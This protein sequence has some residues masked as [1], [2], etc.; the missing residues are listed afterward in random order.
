MRFWLK[1]LVLLSAV[2]VLGC[3]T[4]AQ[5]VTPPEVTAKESVIKGLEGLIETGQGGSEIGLMMQEVDKLHSLD[6]ELAKEL[7]N[8]LQNMMS[9][10]SPEGIKSKAA[11]LLEKVKALDTGG[12]AESGG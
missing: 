3:G 11:E 10:P 1:C 12:A 8:E 2:S 6:P 7:A 9:S 4:D 5:E